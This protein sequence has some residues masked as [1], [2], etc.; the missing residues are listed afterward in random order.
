MRFISLL[1]IGV[2]GCSLVGCRSV[3][4]KDTSISITLN[5]SLYWK[6]VSGDSLVKVPGSYV[7]LVVLPNR[8][9]VGESK[10]KKDGQAT[11]SVVKL[12]GDTI[13]VSASCDSLELMI[14][15]LNEELIK[16]NKEKEDLREKVRPSK[17][18][19]KDRLGDGL[20]GFAIGVL[21][22]CLVK[23]KSS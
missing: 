10:E 13:V 23:R 14:N 1:F 6:R 11:V 5:D 7:P 17:G 3:P 21:S 12:P 16:V 9:E 4:S 19:W 2:V 8:M 22:L 15:I 20:I 18:S